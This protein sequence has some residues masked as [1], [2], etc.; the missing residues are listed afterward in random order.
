MHPAHLEALVQEL[1]GLLL[2]HVGAVLLPHQR[3]RQVVA[4]PCSQAPGST[5]AN[6]GRTLRRHEGAKP[7]CPVV[8][9]SH[10]SR[11][12]PAHPPTCGQVVICVIGANH[13]HSAQEGLARVEAAHHQAVPQRV[14]SAGQGS[15]RGQGRAGQGGYAECGKQQAAKTPQPHCWHTH[16]SGL[17]RTGRTGRQ[18][19]AWQ[20]PTTLLPRTGQ[21]DG[22]SAAW[23]QPT[24]R[25]TPPPHPPPP[26]TP[27]SPN[28]L[29]A[30]VVEHAAEV[31]VHLCGLQAMAVV[32]AEVVV[33]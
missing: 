21:A 31:C 28:S 27:N 29:V 17:L 2:A 9:P 10:P 25:I 4:K 14:H 1:R 19:A 22:G 23:Q 8:V 3:P 11:P 6:Q 12:P 33:A 32:H 26:I 5:V 13:A 16:C 30:A 15:T 20:L 7:S 18:A 24:T